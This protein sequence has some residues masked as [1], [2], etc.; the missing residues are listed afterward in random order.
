ML[1]SESECMKI[2]VVLGI[3]FSV[4][5][6][7]MNA[8]VIASAS[9]VCEWLIKDPVHSWLDWSV[10]VC[11]QKYPWCLYTVLV[12]GLSCASCIMVFA[13][14]TRTIAQAVVGLSD[15]SL[16]VSIVLVT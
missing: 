5:K 7:Y 15:C 14:V 6:T 16:S 2:V 4:D 11:E 1:L 10:V 3:L 12:V 9:A 13:A 8:C